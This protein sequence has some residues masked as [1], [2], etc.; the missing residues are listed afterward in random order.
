MPM[1][2][3][4]IECSKFCNE[5]L[6]VN[7]GWVVDLNVNKVLQKLTHI[8]ILNEDVCEVRL[9]GSGSGI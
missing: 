9:Q 3:K 7:V 8:K 1:N 4:I 2:R 5:V 6:N